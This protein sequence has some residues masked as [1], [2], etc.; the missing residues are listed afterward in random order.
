MNAFGKLPNELL[1]KI[2]FHL[3]DVRREDSRQLR[4]LALVS[5]KL[6]GIAQDA[7]Y[8]S[9]YIN[10]G[11]LDRSSRPLQITQFLRTLLTR[12]ELAKSVRNL[13][14][15]VFDHEGHH[16]DDCDGVEITVMQPDQ[17]VDSKESNQCACIRSRVFTLA[18]DYLAT[19]TLPGPLLRRKDPWREQ[20]RHGFECALAGLILVLCQSLETLELQIYGTSL[21]ANPLSTPTRTCILWN[22]WFGLVPDG[23]NAMFPAA[24]VA[25]LGNL[26]R[27]STNGLVPWSIIALP[28]LDRLHFALENDLWNKVPEEMEIGIP[29]NLA[30]NITKLSIEVE[31]DG[32]VMDPQEHGPHSAHMSRHFA[33]S[34]AACIEL[35]HLHISLQRR[36][37]RRMALV[38]QYGYLTDLIRCPKLETLSIDAHKAL[39]RLSDVHFM[40]DLGPMHSFAHLPSLRRIAAPQEA[41]FEVGGPFRRATLPPSIEEIHIIDYGNAIDRY[42]WRLLKTRYAMPHLK[43]LVTWIDHCKS[44]SEDDVRLYDKF[45]TTK[46]PVDLSM[47]YASPDPNI[48]ADPQSPLEWQR[49]FLD[50]CSHR[51]ELKEAMR[52]TGI[53]WEQCSG[54]R[55]WTYLAIPKHSFK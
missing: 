53:A 55:G 4:N 34:L 5:R 23:E 50:C 45:H 38:G 11:S 31:A 2:A 10:L 13:H 12:P 43:R 3:G 52:D 47:D 16:E 14:I 7:L 30:P 29:R 18:E 36:R 48:L 28:N 25:G 22:M 15:E 21:L 35:K 9:P 32:L 41:F 24:C 1:L 44:H 51:A 40:A 46:E 42:L 6:R 49:R 39:S 37:Y 26:K 27:L 20:I 54:E 8:H 17:I 19:E 33:K